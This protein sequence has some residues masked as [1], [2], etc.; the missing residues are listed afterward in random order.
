[1]GSGNFRLPFI[2]ESIYILFIVTEGLFIQINEKYLFN[3]EGEIQFQVLSL[4]E[5]FQSG[6]VF[7]K[8]D[9]PALEILVIAIPL[10][11]YLLK[12]VGL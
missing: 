7:D 2:Y 4:E 1:M 8:V 9:V 10:V 3:L 12:G 6:I 11:H 5:F